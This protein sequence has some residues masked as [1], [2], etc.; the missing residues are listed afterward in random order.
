MFL[1]ET[2][3][4]RKAER[5]CVMICAII[6]H[7]FLGQQASKAQSNQFRFKHLTVDEGL[8]HTDANYITQDSKG[9]IWIGTYFGLN[10]YDGYAV[11]KFYNNNEPVNNAFKNRVRCLLAN[12]CNQIWLGT[13]DGIQRFDPGTETYTDYKVIGT[14]RFTAE[15]LWMPDINTMFIIAD[16]HLLKFHI[17]GHTLVYIPLKM[18]Y[19]NRVYDFA[20]LSAENLLVATDKGV[21]SLDSKGA[22]RKFILERPVPVT[23][24]CLF[25]DRQNNVLLAGNG[26]IYR[27]IPQANNHRYLIRDS[28]SLP[29][30]NSATQIVQDSRGDYWTK[31]S[32]NIVRIGQDFKVKQVIKAG[33]GNYDLNSASVSGILVDR[34][35][36][37]WVATFSGG[38]NYCDLNQKQFYTFQHEPGNRNSLSGNYVRSILAEKHALW[39]GTMGHGLNRPVHHLN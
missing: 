35:Q 18:Q 26:H 36:C 19:N 25:L 5:G 31:A 7:I 6:L 21:V 16:G 29:D 12:D 10:R 2:I 33:Q 8:S 4:L 17:V 20:S 37:L 39:I 32:P 9:F 14:A 11:K 34:S 3:L 24:K 1:T 22:L 15:K 38:V 23:I 27:A 13:E 28:V 30:H